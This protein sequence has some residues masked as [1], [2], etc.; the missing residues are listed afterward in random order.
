M[1]STR[2]TLMDRAPPPR[3]G[4]YRD[5]P[6]GPS[7]ARRARTAARSRRPRPSPSCRGPS[8]SST[9]SS[10]TSAS[11]VVGRPWA[12]SRAA[13]LRRAARRRRRGAGPRAGPGRPPRRG[14]SA[15][16]PS[17]PRS[18][19]RPCGPRLSTARLPESR[20]SSATISILVRAQSK[21]TSPS[22]AGSSELDAANALPQ[23]AAGEQRRLQHL[24]EARRELLRRAGSPASPGRPGPRSACGRRR[25]SSWP[26]PG[27]RRS[28]RRRPSPPGRPASSAPAPAAR[29]AGRWRRRSPPRSPT[30][31]PPKASTRS[32]RRAPASASSPSTRSA[33]AMVF[34]DSQPSTSIVSSRS[35]RSPRGG[36]S[37]L[38]IGDAEDA[39]RAA[40]RAPRRG[41]PSSSPS[42]PRPDQRRVGAAGGLGPDHPH[43]RCRPHRREPRRGAR[44]GLARVAGQDRPRQRLVQRLRARRSGA[45]TPRGPSPAAGRRRA[46]RA[47]R[48]VS[49][50]D[51]APDGRCGRRAPRGS[52]SLS[53]APPPSAI[54]DRR[55]VVARGLEQLQHE[56][57]LA[58]AELVLA[59]A[60]E[61]GRDR[62]AELALDQLVGVLGDACPAAPPRRA[63]PRSCPPP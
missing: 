51:P 56:L 41:R 16:S 53:T 24:D 13:D 30:T 32:S 44:G 36:D 33:S 47:P 7:G 11:S 20:S 43:A 46:T 62:L 3:R 34:D 15:R 40:R 10:S 23:R 31:P 1:T 60:L 49:S 5:R 4:P 12:A 28:C 6:A 38:G 14:G 25:R 35:G 27:R 58:P 42:A 39:L 26:R 37:A 2:L 55:R 50:S 18:R 9:A 57:L 29:R 59:L 19:G 52:R 45:R 54:T 17:R 21:T 8:R 61:E 22:C 63:P 48:P